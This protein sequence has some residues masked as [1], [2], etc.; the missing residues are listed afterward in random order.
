MS[1]S[2]VTSKGQITIP[3]VVRERL[4]LEPGDKVYFDVQDD[5]S[6]SLIT[7]KHPIE[8]LFG[9]LKAKVKLKRPITIEEMN[10]ASMDDTHK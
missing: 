5:G 2:T 8:S 7:R 1:E 6:V 10:P 9:L 3:K 4:H